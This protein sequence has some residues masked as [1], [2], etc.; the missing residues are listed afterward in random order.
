MLAQ[1]ARAYKSVAVTT[2][3]PGQ[4]VLMLFDGAL[5]F[6]SGALHGFE[7]ENFSRRIEIVHT[8]SIKTQKILRELQCSL[9][10]KQGGEFAQRMYALYDFMIDQ[11]MKSNI[12]KDPEPML[13][14]QDL[15]GQIRGAW[16]EM[17]EQSVAKAA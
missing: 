2:A 17:L 5:R 11:L 15:L 3:T 9:D 14:V 12:S 1:Y 13:V 16:S 4:L 8:N 7:Q 6:I 10:L